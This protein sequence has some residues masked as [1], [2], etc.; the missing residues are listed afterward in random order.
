MAFEIS[1]VYLTVQSQFVIKSDIIFSYTYQSALLIRLNFFC[2]HTW[3]IITIHDIFNIMLSCSPARC[4]NLIITY[5]RVVQIILKEIARRPNLH[6]WLMDTGISNKYRVADIL[7]SWKHIHY[8]RHDV[9]YHNIRFDSQLWCT[10]RLLNT[11]HFWWTN[12][13][14]C[15]PSPQQH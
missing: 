13:S 11:R 2:D 14:V 12:V 6:Q 15:V 10:H 9:I 7:S 5:C 1:Q 4:C 3:S 8:A